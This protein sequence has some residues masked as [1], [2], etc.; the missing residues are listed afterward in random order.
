MWPDE[1]PS[2]DDLIKLAEAIAHV[3]VQQ[4][5]KSKDANLP[6]PGFLAHC[7]VGC[8]RS[9]AFVAAYI[10]NQ[11][12]IGSKRM[13]V[14]GILQFVRRHRWKAFG[15]GEPDVQ[16]RIVYRVIEIIAMR[17]ADHAGKRRLARFGSSLGC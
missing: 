9:A 1:M 2:Q 15:L 10:G 5:T 6:L 3:R 13:N 17:Y 12:W 7:S 8:E 14:L 16:V 4:R 11:M